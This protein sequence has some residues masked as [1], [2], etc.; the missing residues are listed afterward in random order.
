MP[1]LHP[2]TNYNLLLRAICGSPVEKKS[3]MM[4]ATRN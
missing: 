2:K 3:P 4:R 1:L